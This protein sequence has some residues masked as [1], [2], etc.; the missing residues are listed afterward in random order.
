MELD[1]TRYVELVFLNSQT[2][3]LLLKWYDGLTLGF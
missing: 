2:N 3:I 1:M